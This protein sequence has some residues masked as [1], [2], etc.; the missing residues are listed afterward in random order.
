[1]LRRQVHNPPTA[2]P[3]VLQ[4]LQ[5]EPCS[6]SGSSG[7]VLVGPE[8][9]KSC[10]AL[11]QESLVRLRGVS[12][13]MAVTRHCSTKHQLLDWRPYLKQ[14]R[15][16]S[17]YWQQQQQQQQPRC[18]RSIGRCAS[19]SFATTASSLKQVKEADVQLPL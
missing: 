19:P 7:E 16:V 17:Q 10:Y 15:R 18:A 5:L 12:E 14:V 4:R 8:S 1:M 11:T 13:G 3:I 9:V 6:S 2:Q